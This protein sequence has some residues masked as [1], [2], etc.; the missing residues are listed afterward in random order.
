LIDTAEYVF[1]GALGGVPETQEHTRNTNWWDTAT[2][3]FT[4]PEDFR[5]GVPGEFLFAG[6]QELSPKRPRKV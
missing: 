2:G 3:V 6:T 5:G 4:V 1:R